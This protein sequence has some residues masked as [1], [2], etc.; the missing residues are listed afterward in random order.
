MSET[1]REFCSESGK[2]DIYFQQEPSTVFV[3]FVPR[4]KPHKP[5]AKPGS[6]SRRLSGVQA[7]AVIWR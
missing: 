7:F 2:P 4:E 3:A 5:D 6:G 1:V